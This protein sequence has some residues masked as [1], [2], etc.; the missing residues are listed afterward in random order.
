MR[1]KQARPS[2]ITRS[3]VFQSAISPGTTRR[4]A[5]LDGLIERAVA[6]TR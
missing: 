2:E 4:L 1:P 5:S 3:A 6:T